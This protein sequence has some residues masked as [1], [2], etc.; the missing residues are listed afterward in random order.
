MTV[1]ITGKIFLQ[2]FEMKVGKKKREGK[3][4]KT[5]VQ[6]KNGWYDGETKLHIGKHHYNKNYEYKAVRRQEFCHTNTGLRKKSIKDRAN[7]VRKNWQF[8]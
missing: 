6:N 4:L 2:R 8:L 1:T 3:K 7:N 5:N